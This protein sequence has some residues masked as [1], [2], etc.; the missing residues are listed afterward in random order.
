VE[1]T[2]TLEQSYFSIEFLFREFYIRE[3]SML[4]DSENTLSHPSNDYLS[5]SNQQISQ[6]Q[7]FEIIDGNNLQFIKD[8]Y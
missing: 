7:P 1:I 3:L 5:L 6:G 4:R 2:K 8:V